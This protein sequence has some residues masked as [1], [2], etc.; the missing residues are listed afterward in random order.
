MNVGWFVPLGFLREGDCC[1]HKPV[2]GTGDGEESGQCLVN[3]G[4]C[5][6]CAVWDELQYLSYTNELQ[7]ITDVKYIGLTYYKGGF[8]AFFFFFEKLTQFC[9]GVTA[10]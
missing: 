4:Q 2:V 9:C 3:H 1:P 10:L 5:R 6:H 7:S 8:V